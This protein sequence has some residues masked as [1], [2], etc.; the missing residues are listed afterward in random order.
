MLSVRKICGPTL[1]CRLLPL[2]VLLAFVLPAS[3]A[4]VPSPWISK[5]APISACPA[6]A[7]A[8]QTN[9]IPIDR[10]DPLSGT[11]ALHPGDS[12]T[13]LGTLIQ[14]ESRAQ[15]LLYVEAAAPDPGKT[16]AKKPSPFVVTMFG[17][18]MKFESKPVP[19]KLRM[20]GPFSVEG[21]SKP[22]K[23]EEKDAQF[24]LNESFLSL[25]LEQAAAVWWQWS[26]MTNTDLAPSN[27]PPAKS[28]TNKAR[29]WNADRQPTA[30]EQRALAGSIPALM[31]YFEIVQHTEGLEKL[32]FKLVKLP[33]LWSVI[34]HAGVRTDI[35]LGEDTFPANPADWNLPASAPVYYFPCLLRING[36]PAMNITFVVTSPQPPLLVCGGVAGVL[37]EKVG[38]DQTYMTLRVIDARCKTDQEE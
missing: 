14:K 35:L 4:D 7:T 38:D 20:L 13:M 10:M 8:A 9:H 37:A 1:V 11:N 2:S 21:M 29:G 25:G 31:S 15:W 3:S 17:T 28:G 27:S 22:L 5:L 30:A 24:S 23:P 19:A 36:Q 32:L 18:T 16:P 26:Q 6:L 34:R 12:V 33:S